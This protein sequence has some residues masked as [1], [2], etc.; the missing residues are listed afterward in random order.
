MSQIAEVLIIEEQKP[1]FCVS[2]FP[3]RKAVLALYALLSPHNYNNQNYTIYFLTNP[4][5]L[6][7]IRANCGI[8]P[9]EANDQIRHAI[10]FHVRLVSGGAIGQP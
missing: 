10:G 5:K 7:L 8:S 4:E 2:D 6:S 9:F 1:W 3:P